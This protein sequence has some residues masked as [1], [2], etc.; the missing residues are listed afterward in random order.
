MLGYYL[1]KREHLK[2]GMQYE[3]YNERV[4]FAETTI[5]IWQLRHIQEFFRI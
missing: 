3:N 4:F 2:N 5:L 1:Q